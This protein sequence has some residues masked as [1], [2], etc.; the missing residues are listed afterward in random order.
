VPVSRLA[1]I[2]GIGV[3]R[4]GDLADAAGD[5]SILRLENLD[6][7][8]RPPPEAIA[9]T[10]AAIDDDAAN[11]YL[12]FPGHRFIRMIGWRV[13]W[14][15]GSPEVVADVG[16]VGLTNVVC[17]VGIA[18]AAA[19]AALTA[20]DDGIAAAAEWQRR[21]DVLLEELAGAAGHAAARRLVA[22]SR[23][24]RARARGVRGFASPVL[25]RADRDDPDGW[26]GPSA[27]CYVRF[28]FA[29]EPVERLR[30]IGERVRAALA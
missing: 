15:V 25:A 16:L 27:S 20:P 30:G 23:R 5:P 17:Q 9:A 12:P 13:G 10:R 14:V 4:M 2:P 28:V 8:L 22:P 19:A 11:S 18:Q 6:T 24:R 21:R 3:D 29:N 26:L 1:Q 7:D